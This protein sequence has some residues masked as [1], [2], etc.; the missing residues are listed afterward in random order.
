[1]RPFW[2]GSD[3]VLLFFL[4]ARYSRLRSAF[5]RRSAFPVPFCLLELQVSLRR[6]LAVP[7]RLCSDGVLLFY[8]PIVF[9]RFA[10][11]FRVPLICIPRSHRFA[12]RS[13][14]DPRT[15]HS[16]PR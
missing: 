7:C 12:F 2:L 16:E 14:I 3:G 5:H 13:A 1:M 11:A 9:Q 10:A 4:R 15:L 8:F 6:T